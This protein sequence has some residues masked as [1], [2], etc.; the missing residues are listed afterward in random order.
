MTSKTKHTHLIK[1]EAKR[2]GFLSCGI[3]KARFLEE[4]AP[5]LEKWLQQNMQGGMH[6]MENHFDKRLDPTK[7]VEGSKSIISLLLNYYP[8][9]VQNPDS[10][11]LSKYAYGTDYH[12]VIKDKLKSL[13]HFIQAEIGEVNGR[14]F[15]DS[16]PVLD[17]AW[18]AKSG[19]GWIGKH[20]N[21]LTQQVGSFYF[22]AELIID[23]ELE[24]DTP[25]TD[26]CGTCTACIDACPTE[27]IVEP[28]VVDGSKCISYFT[29]ELKENIPSEFKGKF[30]D[31]M[32]G[33]DVC[34]DVCPWNR[35][36]KA[37]SEPLFNPHPELLSMS[38]K[39]WEE[40]TK[41][42]FQKFFKKSAVKRTKFSGLKRNI[43][44]LKD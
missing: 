30:E 41:E 40:I 32:F 6:Y 26:H 2:L 31:W 8:K 9:Q 22:I 15:V 25:V 38:K 28:Y 44:F 29:I 39:D 4:E 10:Y 24:Y 7:L 16:A 21:L 14:A 37:H 27:A 36:S 19:L 42:T 18:A 1:T 13:L 5:R 34:Q 20:S 33:C 17:K 35:F 3:S 12:F 11:K 23:L 43:K